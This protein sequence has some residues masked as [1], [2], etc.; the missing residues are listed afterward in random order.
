[1]SPHPLNG[2]VAPPMAIPPPPQQALLCLHPNGHLFINHCYSLY[3]VYSAISIVVFIAIYMILFHLILH[4]G[5]RHLRFSLYP[6]I[7]PANPVHVRLNT[8]N[9]TDSALPC[10]FSSSAACMLS[11]F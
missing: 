2:L 10:Y 8:L 4:V 1:M 7:T 9:L 5:A 3:G 11:L 6:A